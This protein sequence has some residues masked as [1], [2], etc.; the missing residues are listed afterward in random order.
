MIITCTYIT[1]SLVSK[2]HLYI[3]K[4]MY[5]LLFMYYNIH[6]ILLYVTDLIK[7]IITKYNIVHNSLF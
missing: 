6:C 4:Y 1:N 3:V 7:N 2:I 5:I